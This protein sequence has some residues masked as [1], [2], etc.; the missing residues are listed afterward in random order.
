MRHR[1]VAHPT[2]ILVDSEANS[3]PAIHTFRRAGFCH[4]PLGEQR[5]LWFQFFPDPNGDVLAGRVFESRNFVE[6]KMIQSFPKR[7]KDLAYIGII[8][9]PAEDWL[10]FSGYHN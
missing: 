7:L 5:K 2:E 8:K 3:V 6:V 1:A 10:T 4:C 9:N